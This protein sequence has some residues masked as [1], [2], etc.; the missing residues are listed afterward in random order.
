MRIISFDVGMKNLAYCIFSIPDTFAFTGAS[1]SEL[2]H[3]IKIER[4]DVIDLR[5]PPNLSDGTHTEA[6]P[7]PPPPKR[8]CCNDGKL[9]KWVAQP[10]LVAPTAPLASAS[11]E[12][13]DS[14]SH[15]T[16]LAVGGGG[17]GRGG[18][19]GGGVGGGGVGRGGVGG[20]GV[21][22]G[23]VGGGGVGRGGVGGGGVGGGGVGGGGV[24]SATPILYCAKCAEKSKY[25]T[26]SREILPIKRNPDLLQKKKLGE[27]MDIKA[28]LV[29]Q[30]TG[31][32]P[33]APAAN[34]KLRKADLVQEIVTILARDY[35]EPFDETKYSSYITGIVPPV[36]PKKANYIYAH[37]LDLI[38]YGRNMM[39]HLDAILF[40]E[41]S[42]GAGQ[43][44]ID[45]MII[46]NQ[47]S[48]LASR[49]KTLQ[50][51][52]T[53]YF[54]MKHI[55]QIEFISAS[56]KL[57][58]FTDVNLDHT[59]EEEICVDASTYADRKKSGILVCRSLGEIS[60]KHHSDFAK[61]MPVFENHKK[62]DDLADC[63]L[64]GLWRVH[65]AV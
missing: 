35:L 16:I 45:M 56:C 64:Q 27:L 21:G 30:A 65:S 46:E 48:T 31:G 5:F 33:P 42:N 28:N 24:A 60:R 12:P 22:G 62:K 10:S 34:L 29:A 8:T 61:W 15:Q 47:I 23:G 43:A 63:F 2:I 37:D 9:A 58:L 19:G 59:S 40:T 36:K 26:P 6:P 4:W 57:K 44:P 41:S 38:T 50:G 17:V 1:P 53:Q 11:L 52:I 25:K 18:V 55:P 51:M 49:M 13:L 39:K 3:R 20:G 14:G 7:P 32:A 54:I